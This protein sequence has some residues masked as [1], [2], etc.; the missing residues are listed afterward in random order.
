[1]YTYLPKLIELHN[2]KDGIVLLEKGAFL[3]DEQIIGTSKILQIPTNKLENTNAPINYYTNYSFSI[4]VYLNVQANNFD[5][6]TKETTIFDFGKGKP[7][8]T[9]YNNITD[10][11]HKNKYIIYFTD[12]TISGPVTFETSLSLQ[13]WNNFVF[14][15]KSTHV[16]LFING[17]LVKV[18][19]FNDNNKIPTY[20]STNN[21]IIGSDNGLDGAIGNIL[22]Y[23][24]NL[25][26]SQ[27]T[28]NYNILMY[29]NPP[30][31][32]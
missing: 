16:D 27:I 2:K 11:L 15:Y 6:Y 29:K 26:T 8:I 23:P 4:W 17:E 32:T 10:D 18:F 3:N 9:Y 30:W 20:T 13:K 14:N 28:T 1:V 5:S 12:N 31:S 22:F 21:I 24:Y 19:Q 25:T 7:K